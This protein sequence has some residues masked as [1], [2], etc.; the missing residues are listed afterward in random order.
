MNW[1]PWTSEGEIPTRNQGSL[2]IFRCQSSPWALRL[3]TR[4]SRPRWKLDFP[5]LQNDLCM[6]GF[7]DFEMIVESNI[8]VWNRIATKRL[9]V[10]FSERF[11]YERGHMVKFLTKM[12]HI[13]RWIRKFDGQKERR[14]MLEPYKVMAIYVGTTSGCDYTCGMC[15][16]W[17]GE[18]QTERNVNLS[19]WPQITWTPRFSTSSVR[20]LPQLSKQGRRQ[21]LWWKQLNLQ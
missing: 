19:L 12:V 15:E 16:A 10:V 11:R 20:W 9:T 13:A 2:K 4:R 5:C 7:V 6:M 17:D 1:C 8:V 3:A 14:Y 21:L 18:V